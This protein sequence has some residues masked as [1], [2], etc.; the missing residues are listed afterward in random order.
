MPYTMNLYTNGGC[1]PNSQTG[2]IAA[3]AVVM[4]NKYSHRTIWTRRLP[5]S[6]VPT[7]QRAKLCAIILAL[8]Q[9]QLKAQ[10]MRSRP[11]MDITILTDSK[12][13]IGCMTEWCQK[14]MRN[15]FR[16]SRGR[17]VANRDLIERALLLE[18]DVLGAGTVDW[19]WVPR[20]RNE[21]AEAVVDGVLDE[22]E[23]GYEDSGS[24]SPIRAS[25]ERG[26]W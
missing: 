4:T 23:P 12:Y 22:M 19:V 18:G 15:G 16:S 14:W 8:E 20:S 9:A 11:H 2:P 7:S 1:R 5:S 25:W 17:E 10:Q 6:P 24:D 13:V 26:D 3:A 21:V